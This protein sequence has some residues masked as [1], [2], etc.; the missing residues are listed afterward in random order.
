MAPFSESSIESKDRLFGLCQIIVGGFG[1]HPGD[2]GV[3]LRPHAAGEGTAGVKRGPPL[4]AL[5]PAGR[6]VVFAVAIKIA[7]PGID[8]RSART[9]GRPF[10][11][12]KGSARANSRPP[13]TT[14]KISPGDIR[15]AVAVEIADLDIDPSGRGAPGS[16]QST[17]KSGPGTACS[18]AIRRLTRPPL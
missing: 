14:F 2:A 7:D 9:P 16:P 5:L 15:Q 4:A 1:I 6:D 8:P 13:L 3:P 12:D 18:S 10:G 11:A 17:D